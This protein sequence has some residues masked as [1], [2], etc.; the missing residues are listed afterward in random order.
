VSV[1]PYNA[2][3][4]LSHLTGASDGLLL[5]Q[6]EVLHATC[7]KALGL[8]RPGFSVRGAAG[9]ANRIAGPEASALRPA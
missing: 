7:T 6:N 2:L 3:L 1:Q 5:L 8:Q 9:A 4:T